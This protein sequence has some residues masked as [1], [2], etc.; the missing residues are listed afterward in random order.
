M[1]ITIEAPDNATVGDIIS[2]LF[3]DADV[4]EFEPKY[5]EAVEKAKR[6]G[7]KMPPSAKIKIG[8]KL[9]AWVDLSWWNSSFHGGEDE[10]IN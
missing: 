1:K 4:K 7:F 5:P 9:L 3:P 8:D 6:L 2:K 10:S